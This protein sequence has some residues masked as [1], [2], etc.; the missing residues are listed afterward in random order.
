MYVN[1]VLFSYVFLVS[2]THHIVIH[3]YNNHS[4]VSALLFTT[5]ERFRHRSH[6]VSGGVDVSRGHDGLFYDKCLSEYQK[7]K[8]LFFKRLRNEIPV[9]N[10]LTKFKRHFGR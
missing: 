8:N 1:L 10:A 4:V 7:E 5:Y 2:E 3:F 9:A 6:H